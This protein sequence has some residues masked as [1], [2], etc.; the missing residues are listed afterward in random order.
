MVCR[1]DFV[2]LEDAKL[3][4]TDVDFN[5]QI[6]KL[7]PGLLARLCPLLL[8]ASLQRELPCPLFRLSVILLNR[9]CLYRLHACV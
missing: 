1:R 7:L 4:I 9:V 6:L 5:A 8:S 2:A 3:A